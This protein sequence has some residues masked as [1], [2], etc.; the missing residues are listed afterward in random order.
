MRLF[1]VEFPSAKLW[2]KGHEWSWRCS[3]ALW[4]IWVVKHLETYAIGWPSLL[5][6]SWQLRSLRLR[7]V[8]LLSQLRRHSWLPGS[9]KVSTNEITRQAPQARKPLSAMSNMDMS[10]EHSWGLFILSEIKV[11]RFISRFHLWPKFSVCLGPHTNTCV[12]RLDIDL[13]CL[14][15]HPPP[16]TSLT[17]GFLCRYEETVSWLYTIM[18]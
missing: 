10:R 15:N 9:S 2:K 8:L 17:P 3:H 5:F 6:G 7:V 16:L 13:S 12:W 18:F 11:G 1:S 14:S 4:K